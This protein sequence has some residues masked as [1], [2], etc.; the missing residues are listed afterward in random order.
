[1]SKK[2]LL[3]VICSLL[4]ILS[5]FVALV[6]CG[7]SGDSAGQNDATNPPLKHLAMP[8]PPI[9]AVAATM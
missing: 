2:R 3:N 6:G 5:L 1:M 8:M 4:L 7:K 9:T